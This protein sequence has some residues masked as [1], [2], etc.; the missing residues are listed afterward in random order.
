MAILYYCGSLAFDFKEATTMQRDG[1]HPT[2]GSVT[3][4]TRDFYDEIFSALLSNPVLRKALRKITTENL[5]NNWKML[6]DPKCS[7]V[8]FPKGRVKLTPCIKEVDTEEVVVTI[9]IRIEGATLKEIELVVEKCIEESFFKCTD[10]EISL[11]LRKLAQSQS[12]KF[13]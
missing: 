1:V 7:G 13:T 8:Y 2:L 6:I 11:R 9:P 3:P 12:W 5:E 10:G 4:I